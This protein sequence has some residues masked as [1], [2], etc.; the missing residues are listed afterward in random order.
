GIVGTT[1]GLV[2]ARAERD[3]KEKAR[4]EAD[5][6]RADAT[7]KAEAE[8]QAR[9]DATAKAEAER[10]ARRATVQTLTDT[11][12][13]FR[14]TAGARD[15]H[16]QA[17]LW[18]ANAARLAGDDRARAD[19]N[20]IRVAAWGRL[21]IQP[22]RALVHPAEFV[23]NNMVFHPGGRHLLTHGFDP[24]TQETDCRLWD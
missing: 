17:V 23:E 11:D 6:A 19:A 9:A 1:L 15:D 5:D 4:Q 7:A 14:L 24:A 18:F 22:V 8:R 13:S 16:R 3:E 2:Q 20:R 12:T 21:A 10:Q